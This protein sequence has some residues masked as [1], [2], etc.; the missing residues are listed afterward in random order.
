MKNKIDDRN[1]QFCSKCS[2]DHIR[3]DDI[4]LLDTYNEIHCCAICGF[5]SAPDVDLT[6]FLKSER[7]DDPPTYDRDNDNSLSRY[8]YEYKILED[9]DLAHHV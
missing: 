7:L 4:L 8:V 2:H 1:F 9:C 5:S 3:Q 6:V